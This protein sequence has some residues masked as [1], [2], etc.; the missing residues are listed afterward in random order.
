MNMRDVLKLKYRNE[1]SCVLLL[2][3]RSVV[4]AEPLAQGSHWTEVNGHRQYYEVHGKGRP[5]LLLHG[6]G[7]S[8]GSSFEK[9][10]KGFSKTHL[11][12]LPDQVGQ[13]RTP[14]VPGP[15][16]YLGM[17]NDTVVLMKSLGVQE[18]DVVG[19]S[20]GGILALML[21]VRHPELVRREVVS[22]VNIAPDGLT[23]DTIE[24]L[25]AMPADDTQSVGVK[26]RN[27]WLSSPT[28]AELNIEMLH[29]I[30]DSVL[31]ISGDHDA[32]TL[33]HTLQIYRAIP[34]A[35]LCILP[36]TEHDTFS[37]RSEWLNP[38]ALGFLEVK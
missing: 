12:I 35:Q 23:P 1:L 3:A 34:H 20:D 29:K 27:L 25:R 32:I 2:L 17:M 18:A 31:V 7:D 9:Q 28:P 30:K 16:T 11:L 36:N 4:A 5:L 24:G 22:G 13:G 21:A 15:L 19:F 33:D 26:L 14:D 10:L 38:I 6:G 37:L 8:G